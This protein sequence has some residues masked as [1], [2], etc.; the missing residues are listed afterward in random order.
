MTYDEQEIKQEREGRV[1][2]GVA[3]SLRW[4]G[5]GQPGRRQPVSRGGKR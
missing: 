2:R 3:Y 4:Q 5:L 1:V